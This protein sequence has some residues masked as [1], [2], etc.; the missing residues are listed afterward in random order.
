VTIDPERARRLVE[1]ADAQLPAAW[2]PA[3]AESGHPTTLVGVFV[4]LSGPHQTAYG[5][6]RVVV[7]R[8]EHGV[9]WAVWL[10]HTVLR[11]EFARARPHVGELVAVKYEGRRQPDGGGHGYASYRVVVDRD[12]TP[13]D[14]TAVGDSDD[15]APPVSSS[16]TPRCDACQYPHPTHAT[17]CPHDIPF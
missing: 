5:P 16:S 17:G 1:Q 10:L 13:I 3:N 7:L 2:M 15:Q 8:D 11:N 6:A 9:E 12:D 4:N 14:W